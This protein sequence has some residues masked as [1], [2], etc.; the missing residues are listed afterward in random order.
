[1]EAAACTRKY[2]SVG[3]GLSTVKFYR[4]GRLEDRAHSCF[5]PD[6]FDTLADW[7]TFNAGAKNDWRT[8]SF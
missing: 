5:K 1:M 6:V 8:G 3:T 4:T 2:K 7:L